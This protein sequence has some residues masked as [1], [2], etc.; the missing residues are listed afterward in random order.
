MEPLATTADYQ[1][2][3]GTPSS[4]DQV[5][6]LLDD[7]SSFVREE[8]RQTIS[9][10]SDDEVVLVGDGSDLVQLPELPVVEVTS[11]SVEGTDLAAGEWKL[12]PVGQ[13]RRRGGC[14]RHDDLIT[15]TYSHGWDPV[16][17]WVVNLICS[18]VQ[19]ALRPAAQLGVQGQT[20]G[21]QSI[22]YASSVAGVNLWLTR[23]EQARLHALRPPGVA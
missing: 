19:R 23:A 7:A 12:L 5:A 2:R 3:H 14:W 1:V 16:P 22:Q 21:S 9:R 10:V 8:S 6:V 13:I 4:A 17:D 20:V 18:T 11:V 15:V